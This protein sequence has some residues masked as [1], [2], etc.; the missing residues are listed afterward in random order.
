MFQIFFKGFM[1]E[2]MVLTETKNE[3]QAQ[4]GNEGVNHHDGFLVA[5]AESEVLY[6][7]VCILTR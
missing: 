5:Y 2:L 3:K 6:S 7:Y 4:W 1:P